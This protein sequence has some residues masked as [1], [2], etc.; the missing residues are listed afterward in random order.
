MRWDLQFYHS[1]PSSGPNDYRRTIIDPSPL[2]GSR[3]RTASYFLPNCSDFRVEFTYDDPRD[4]HD[5]YK[6]DE[7]GTVGDP[8]SPGEPNPFT[9][10]IRWL[11]IAPNTQWVWSKIS[12]YPA[13]PTQTNR[14]PAD[15]TQ[16]NRWPTAIRITMK[17]WD[18][19]GRL[20]EPVTYTLI[21][22]W[23]SGG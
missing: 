22:T 8:L 20:E 4:V 17:A 2:M 19:G 5:S 10:P 3:A 15:P 13:D 11:T 23:P 12:A 7:S 18:A 16:T 21:H 6:W 1:A 9:R 14:W